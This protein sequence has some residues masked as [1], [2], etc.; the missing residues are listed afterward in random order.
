V[1]LVKAIQEKQE[2]IKQLQ[3]RIAKLEE[4]Y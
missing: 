4:K 2:I 1:P 3:E